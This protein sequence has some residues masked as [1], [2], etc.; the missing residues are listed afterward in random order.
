MLYFL[1]EN[2]VKSFL[3]ADPKFV[4]L[5]GFPSPQPF[6]FGFLLLDRFFN[7]GNIFVFPPLL[8][9]VNMALCLLLH[10]I[11]PYGCMALCL[12]GLMAV[13]PYGCMALCL[14]GL[15]TLWPYGIWPSGI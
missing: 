8:H 10:S 1:A 15:V 4:L 2:K 5:T 6:F 12:Y 13:W 14:Y 11:W 3:K 7:F 9:C